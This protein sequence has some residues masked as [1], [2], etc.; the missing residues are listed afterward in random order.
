MEA[1]KKSLKQRWFE[2]GFIAFVVLLLSIVFTQNHI[3]R[4]SGPSSDQ[5]TYSFA[6]TTIV[7]VDSVALDTL[8]AITPVDTLTADT[9]K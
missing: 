8:R 7:S 3:T 4:K 1:P 2:F 5:E 6:D 9:L